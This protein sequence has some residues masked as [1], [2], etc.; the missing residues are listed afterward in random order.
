MGRNLLANLSKKASF[1][2][3]FFCGYCSNAFQLRL[4]LL[5][6]NDG[7]K[8]E[9]WYIHKELCVWDKKEG[10][11]AAAGYADGSSLMYAGK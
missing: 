4:I 11:Q 6:V 8:Y 9:M 7:G 1:L 5:L 2:Q 10:L 3:V